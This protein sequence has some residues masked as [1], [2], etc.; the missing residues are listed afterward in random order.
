[1]SVIAEQII[2]RRKAKEKLPTFYRTKSIVYPP[3]LNLEQCSSEETARFKSTF[4]VNALIQK[5]LCADLTGG[6]GVDSFFFSRAFREVYYIEHN[7]DLL[8]SH[9]II[10]NN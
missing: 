10:T 8:G 9:S 3:S 6:F 1:M 4:A 2:G 7:A 5:V